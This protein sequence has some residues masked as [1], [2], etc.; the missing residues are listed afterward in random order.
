MLSPLAM[1]SYS[2]VTV[3]ERWEAVLLSPLLIIP[4]RRN[5]TTAMSSTERWHFV[6]AIWRRV[7][8]NANIRS[9]PWWANSVDVLSAEAP[10]VQHYLPEV[11]PELHPNEGIEDGIET[12]VEVSHASGN[13]QNLEFNLFR[14]TTPL[15]KKRQSVVQQGHIEGKVA[16][17]ENHN[18]CPNNPDGLVPLAALCSQ[19]GAH[20][21]GVAE[22]H[23]QQRQQEAN[24]HLKAGNKH[25]H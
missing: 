7:G 6:G 11:A 5:S 21:S 12:A 16:H 20:D 24:G 25:L 22:H 23:H 2:K 1:Y 10:Q 8:W 18:H 9:S 14:L 13:G 17:D 15:L 19:Q 4:F 3:L